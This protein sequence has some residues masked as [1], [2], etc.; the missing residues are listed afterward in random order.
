MKLIE[1]SNYKMVVQILVIYKYEVIIIIDVL[2][3]ITYYFDR[4]VC[5]R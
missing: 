4:L 5:I 1:H 3:N 2:F